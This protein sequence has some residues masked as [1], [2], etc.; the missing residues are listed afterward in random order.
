MRYL[1]DLKM[2]RSFFYGLKLEG[3]KLPSNQY[4]NISRV[5]RLKCTTPKPKSGN[6]K[7]NIYNCNYIKNRHIVVPELYPRKSQYLKNGVK[8]TF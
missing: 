2:S 5:N 6:N 3:T 1:R 7:L 4:T 8:N